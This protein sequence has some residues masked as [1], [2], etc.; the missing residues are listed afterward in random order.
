MKITIK[1]YFK[2]GE[3]IG[4]DNTLITEQGW[5]QV[6]CSNDD[7]PFSIPADQSVYIQKAQ[8][9]WVKEA[10][11]IVRLSYDKGFTK[12]LSF[13]CGCGYLEYNIKQYAPAIHMTVTDFNINSLNRLKKIHDLYDELKQFDIKKDSV[14]YSE[15]M[16][17]LLFRLDTELTDNEWNQVFHKMK[18]SNVVYVLIVATEILTLRRYLKESIKHLLRNVESYTFCGYIRNKNGLE[19]LW[20]DSYD[21]QNALKIGDLNAYLLKIKDA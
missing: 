14:I 2:F 7:T 15:N 6:R 19:A 18:D 21:V 11:D 17:C 5:D 13:G 9:T 10:R 8:Q 3:L 20:A 1:H 4:I 12:I 16:L